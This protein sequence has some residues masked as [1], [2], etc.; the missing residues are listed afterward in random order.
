M[1]VG[2]V[3]LIG[4]GKGTVA[5]SLVENYSFRQDSF[6]STLKDACSMIFDWP[7]HML[8]GDT[9]ESREWREIVDTWWADKLGIERFSPRLA[10]QLVG[11]DALRNHFHEDIWFLSLANRVRKNSE[12]DVVISDARFPNELAFIKE[13][14]GV[15][16]R[17]KRGPDPDWYSI[18]AA[19]N[20]GDA[21]SKNIMA[22]VYPNV[23]F[24]EWAWAGTEVDYVVDNNGSL[25]DLQNN[26]NSLIK[27]INAR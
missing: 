15:I 17:V 10:L 2:L 6:A 3:G 26:I 18:A 22:S 8:E 25:E 16:V 19:A 12:R 4:S 14:N 1:I 13:N 21:D 9:K 7:R 24:S 23:H 11:T 5:S 27:E 20:R